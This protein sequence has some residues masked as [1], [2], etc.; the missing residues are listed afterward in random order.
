MSQRHDHGYIVSQFRDQTLWSKR[1]A[2]CG[3]IRP[4]AMGWVAIVVALVVIVVL[5]AA[6]VS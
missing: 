1:C 6:V 5:L 2:A 4:T 3:V